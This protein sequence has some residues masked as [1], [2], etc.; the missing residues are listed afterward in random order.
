MAPTIL[1]LL[2]TAAFA[3]GWYS[4]WKTS[5]VD[6]DPFVLAGMFVVTAAGVQI[7]R[8]LWARLRR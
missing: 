6:P 8:D 2:G 5:L 1:Y 4:Y 3:Y 7:V